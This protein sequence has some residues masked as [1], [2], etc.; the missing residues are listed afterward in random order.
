MTYI[1]T[2][3]KSLGFIVSQQ[4]EKGNIDLKKPF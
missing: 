2:V 3:E 4:P 1:F